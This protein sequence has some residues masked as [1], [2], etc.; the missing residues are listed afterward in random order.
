MARRVE[1]NLDRSMLGEIFRQSA[2]MDCKRTLTLLN[3]RFD[4]VQPFDQVL[5]PLTFARPER[6]YAL[7]EDLDFDHGLTARGS[8]ER[9]RL[10]GGDG[11]ERVAAGDGRMRRVRARPEIQLVSNRSANQRL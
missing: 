4:A 7:H 2:R 3:N 10:L 9:L 11:G 5:A 8:R 1:L 6:A